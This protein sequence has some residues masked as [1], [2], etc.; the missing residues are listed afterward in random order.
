MIRLSDEEITI[1]DRFA[2][3]RA[4]KMLCQQALIELDPCEAIQSVCL[5]ELEEAWFIAE[6][7]AW[8]HLVL[9][10]GM[11]GLQYQVQYP[12][13]TMPPADWR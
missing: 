9:V 10:I 5:Q 8:N 1:L 7:R 2:T 11:G 13:T 3:A 4:N 6:A 12:F